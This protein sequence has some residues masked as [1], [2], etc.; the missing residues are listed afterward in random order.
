MSRSLQGAKKMA[1]ARVETL[2][3]ASAAPHMITARIVSLDGARAQL[4]TARGTVEADIDPTVHLSV[5]AT[6]HERGERVLVEV[7]GEHRVIVGALRTQ[8]TPGVDRGEHFA[9]EAKTVSIDA[10]KIALEG[11][12]VKLSSKTARIVLRAA[13][14]IES[15]ADRIVSR[16]EGVHKIVGRMLRLN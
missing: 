8:P 10:E 13:S 4:E 3:V 2:H 15:F 12:E 5:M 1:V 9:I 14:E 16:A 6:A 7:D 11:E